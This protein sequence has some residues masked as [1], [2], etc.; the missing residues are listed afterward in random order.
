MNFVGIIITMG[1]MIV[2]IEILIFG[3]KFI[4]FDIWDKIYYIETT[5]LCNFSYF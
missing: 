1:V 5:Y 3:I 4:D 2:G